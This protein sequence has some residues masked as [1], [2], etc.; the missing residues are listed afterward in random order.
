MQVIDIIQKQRAFVSTGIPATFEHRIRALNRLRHLLT[1]GKDRLLKAVKKD[2]KRPEKFT[3][4]VE[5][6]TCL[7]EIDYFLANLHE[8]MQ[9][10][11]VEKTLTTMI[12]STYVIREPFGTALLIGPFN[13]P[14]SLTILPLIALIGAGNTVVFKPSE[15]TGNVAQ[16]MSELFLEHFDQD[17][18]AVVQADAKKT[19]EI[20]KERFDYICYTGSTTVGRL[21]MKAASEHLTPV[22]LEL[23]G[24]C[25]VFVEPDCD[26]LITAKRI[27]WGKFMSN[28]QTCLSPDYLLTTRTVAQQLIPLMQRIIHEFYGM[29]VQ[30][31]DDYSRIINERHFDRI[32]SL[33][34]KTKGRVLIKSG[35]A[36]R[37]DLFVPPTVVEVQKSDVLMQEELFAPILPIL[38]V[39][40]FD[41]AINYLKSKEK[42]LATYIFTKNNQ[43]ADRLINET[44]S[45]SVLVNDVILNFTVDTLPFGGV[46]NSGYGQYRG[47]HGYET[48]SHKKS[49]V[50][51]GFF[52][53]GIISARYP[54]MTNNKHAA[55]MAL[56]TRRSLPRSMVRFLQYAPFVVFGVLLH[57]MFHSI[58]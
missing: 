38:I 48:F 29:D 5:L 3:D 54:P 49:I 50:K 19:A 30:Q 40:N 57:F 37:D 42:P 46:G 39:E 22:L 23:G 9:P 47:R 15:L 45:G 4:F 8:W 7:T 32:N 25:P 1:S 14:I 58:F 51:R 10:E 18:I 52:A 34:E 28:G 24:K 31:S 2:L 6:S 44:R 11:Y 53:D 56:T 20:L 21:I 12:D 41:E 27:C 43:K 36:N 55:L 16:V 26:L 33:L 17:F 13:Y 35:E